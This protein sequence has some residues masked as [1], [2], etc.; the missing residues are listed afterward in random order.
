MSGLHINAPKPSKAT[1]EI[2]DCPDCKRRSVFV[3]LFT[4]WYGWSQTCLRCGRNWQDGERMALPFCRT[5]RADSAAAA[6]RAYR[7]ARSVVG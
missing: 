1:A 6:R 7:R 4:E 3:A 5:A 2:R